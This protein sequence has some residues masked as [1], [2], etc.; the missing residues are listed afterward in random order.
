MSWSLI[1]FLIIGLP[2]ILLCGSFFILMLLVFK[3]RDKSVNRNQTLEMAR[4]LER[5]LTQMENRLG[6][7]EDILLNPD[8][9]KDAC[10][11]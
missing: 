9:E 6:S 10:H 8:K 3:G 7:L 2:L 5:T 1:L 11:D 4:S